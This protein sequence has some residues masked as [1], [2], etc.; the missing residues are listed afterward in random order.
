MMRH[1]IALFILLI[2]FS[3]AT[4]RAEDAQAV[5]TKTGSITV[6]LTGVENDQGP[7][8][9]CV[10]RSEDEYNGTVKEFCTASTE[11]KNKKAELVF[12]NMP[13]GKYSIK[14]F[15]DENVNN[16]LDKDFMGIP[17][18]RYGFS[19]NARGRFG[20]PSFASTAFTLSA[21][22]MTIAIELK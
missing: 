14:A 22:Q 10:C 15:H 1:A 2:L 13:Y 16:R 9:L 21:P 6:Q 7:V 11:L 4:S 18:E 8:K 12:E 19:N 17:T 3:I 5:N 20:P